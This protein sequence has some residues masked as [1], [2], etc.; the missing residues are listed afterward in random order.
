MLDNRPWDVERRGVL[1]APEPFLGPHECGRAPSAGPERVPMIGATGVQS[2]L[3]GPPAF[4]EADPLA[5]SAPSSPLWGIRDE[6]P[7][8]PPSIGGGGVSALP[9]CDLACGGHAPSLGFIS[10]KHSRIFTP[11]PGSSLIS[12]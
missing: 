6:S 11:F 9:R 10:N 4:A 2:E 1:C 12:L 8:M 7:P 3:C 5:R